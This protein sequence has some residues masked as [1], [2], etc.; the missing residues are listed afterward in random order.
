[1]IAENDQFDLI[2]H[3][4]ENKILQRVKNRKNL[5]NNKINK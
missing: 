3:T 2:K 4:D 1:M 5:I